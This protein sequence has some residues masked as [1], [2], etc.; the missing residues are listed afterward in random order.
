[1]G[2]KKSFIYLICITGIPVTAFAAEPAATASPQPAY[3]EEEPEGLDSY[4]AQDDYHDPVYLDNLDALTSFYWDDYFTQNLRV[5]LANYLYY[6]T[7][8]EDT[9][10]EGAVVRRTLKESP[11]YGG[12]ITFDV[13][14]GE[15][16]IHCEYHKR[17][18]VF[19]FKSVYGD[20]SLNTQFAISKSGKAVSKDTLKEFAET[21]LKKLI[22]ES[23]NIKR[24]A[25]EKV[26]VGQTTWS[27]RLLAPRKWFFLEEGADVSLM[28]NTDYSESQIKSM[29]VYMEKKSKGR[30]NFSSCTPQLIQFYKDS[31]ADIAGML[32]IVLTEGNYR[33]DS[34]AKYWNFYDTEVPAGGT[35]ADGGKYWNAKAD[36]KNMGSAMVTGFQWI[37]TNYWQRGQDTF[38]KMSFYD[39]GYPQSE[40]E[41]DTAPV[42]DHCYNPWFADQAYIASG[43]DDYYAWCNKCARHRAELIKAAR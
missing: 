31:H 20:M 27:G 28:R 43:F 32:A 11:A 37:Y 16:M 9:Y 1:M 15:D 2:I 25:E 13:R 17:L 22:P 7:G 41:A 19:G 4:D 26:W 12:V 8:D 40:E 35:A 10:Y 18:K 14:L 29:L 38:Y 42:L 33:E 6:F 21:K 23:P 24:K 36:C 39:Y 3:E 5:Y 30:V 34:N